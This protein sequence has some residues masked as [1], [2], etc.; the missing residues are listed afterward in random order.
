MDLAHRHAPKGAHASMNNTK[1]KKKRHWLGQRVIDFEDQINAMGMKVTFRWMRAHTGID[2]NERADKAAKRATNP[3]VIK[4][5]SNESFAS[6][7]HVN[8]A[9]TDTK[10]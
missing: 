9:T 5:P 1:K 8:R 4:V 6:L 3:R 10:W 7:A 2:G